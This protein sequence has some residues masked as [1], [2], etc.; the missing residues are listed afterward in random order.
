MI[1]VT[2]NASGRYHVGVTYT[3]ESVPC[4]S[5]WSWGPCVAGSTVTVTDLEPRAPAER[6]GLRVG[7]VLVA[8][9]G[10]AV[11]EKDR[12]NRDVTRMFRTPLLQNGTA[13]FAVTVH[14]D[15]PNPAPT[16][17]SS[18]WPSPRDWWTTPAPG[19]APA[20]PLRVPNSTWAKIVTG[21]TAGFG[22]QLEGEC[23]ADGVVEVET[24]IDAVHHLRMDDFEDK[25]LGLK[26]L[27]Q[28]FQDVPD[29]MKQ[30]NA[31]LGRVHADSLHLK[32]A[33][34]AMKYPGSF[35]FHL[36]QDLLLNGVNIF[37]EVNGATAAWD[38]QDYQ[39]FGMH[40]GRAL[41][42]IV[43]GEGA[44]EAVPHLDPASWPRID[45]RLV[46][47]GVIRGLDMEAEA[48][49]VT[50]SARDLDTLSVGT[51]E[52]LRGKWAWDTAQ[53]RAGLAKWGLAMHN[54]THTVEACGHAVDVAKTQGMPTAIA[55][56]MA[57]AHE[58][59]G[60]I[61]VEVGAY[62][63]YDLLVN[64]Q[65]IYKEVREAY[66]DRVAGNATELGEDIGKVLRLVFWPE[67]KLLVV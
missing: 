40:V 29:M 67:P 28:S 37:H 49:C 32:A 64:G 39:D 14:R 42:Q 4:K 1:P 12:A 62:I 34:Q 52:V 3:W 27:G 16:P 53:V 51:V 8:I 50:G 41:F 44:P 15:A 59:A 43:I 19:S 46:L 56:M 10:E 33:L 65:E 47:V 60:M 31:S 63:G 7:D 2:R 24:V 13:V 55:A 20:P 38:A 18:W 58:G 11:P 6:A 9:N 25:L 66:S 23:F 45:W 30:C 48:A 36:G 61:A 26:T 17:A 22:M 21:V 35:A 5:W 54:L 57:M